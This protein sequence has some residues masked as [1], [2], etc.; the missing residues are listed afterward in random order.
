MPQRRKRKQYNPVLL[1]I[2]EQV[3]FRQIGMGFDLDHRR[4]DSR[5]FTKQMRGRFEI[6]R[7]G[8]S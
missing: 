7:S 8:W 6:S 4:L 5:R 2:F 3:A 1:A